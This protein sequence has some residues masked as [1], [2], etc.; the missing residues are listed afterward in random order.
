MKRIEAAFIAALAPMQHPELGLTRI[1]SDFDGGYVLPRALVEASHG[2][3]SIGVGDNNEADVALATLGK[4]VHAWDHTVAGLP[5]QHSMIT[6]HQ[7]GLGASD[8]SRDLMPLE[9]ILTTSFGSDGGDLILLMDAEG[10]EWSALADVDTRALRRFSVASLE[11]HELG[12]VLVP[13]STILRVLERLREQFVPVAVHANNHAASWRSDGFVLPDAL[14][15]TYVR[16][17]LLPAGAVRGNCPP[18]LLA[19]CCPDIDDIELMW[20]DGPGSEQSTTRAK[21]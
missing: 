9:S 10:A 8:A 7:V 5:V 20:A 3:V 13:G 1:G 16:A 4:E 15:V 17:D 6:F 12:N 11:L 14:E 21:R 19:P 2:V 18:S